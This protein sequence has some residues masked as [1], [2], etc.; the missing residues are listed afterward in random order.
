MGKIFNNIWKDF[1]IKSDNWKT[2]IIEENYLNILNKN[3][4]FTIDSIYSND[5]L[6]KNWMTNF[7]SDLYENRITSI[8]YY[9]TDI[10]DNIKKD[11]KIHTYIWE[12]H[13]TIDEEFL[14]SLDKNENYKII[15]FLED[16]NNNLYYDFWKINLYIKNQTE[17]WIIFSNKVENTH[18]KWEVYFNKFDFTKWFSENYI[19]M[20]Y[21][22]WNTEE[23]DYVKTREEIEF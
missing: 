5:E 3:N 20:K 4:N 13:Y 15:L 2:C 14:Q 1:I 17:H 18:Y 12:K 23:F 11:F 16:D 7:F 6:Y 19:W 22:D 8:E 21:S 10:K 9:D